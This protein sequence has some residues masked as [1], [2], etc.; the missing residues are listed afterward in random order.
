MCKHSGIWSKLFKVLSNLHCW[1]EFLK[2]LTSYKSI[3]HNFTSF[4]FCFAFVRFQWNR[5]HSKCGFSS[6]QVLTTNCWLQTAKEKYHSN[7]MEIIL[8][9]IDR[10]EYSVKV[11]LR[12]LIRE[13]VR[14]GERTLWHTFLNVEHQFLTELPSRQVLSLYQYVCS[15]RSSN[16]LHS[17]LFWYSSSGEKKQFAQI[18]KWE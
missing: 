12:A 14:E 5:L 4:S 11:H 16:F 2:L 8:D 3:S 10:N 7:T 18:T 6:K 15:L 1:N 17:L 9:G 13:N